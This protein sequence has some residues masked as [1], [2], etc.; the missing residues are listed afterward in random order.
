MKSSQRLNERTDMA[1]RGKQKE[2]LDIG[3]KVDHIHLIDA[4]SNLKITHQHHTVIEEYS[5]LARNYQVI[6]SLDGHLD[7]PTGTLFIA[8]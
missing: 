4:K 7:G 3:N 5:E 8:I 1:A 6:A 2:E